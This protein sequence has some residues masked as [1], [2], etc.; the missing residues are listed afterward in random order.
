MRWSC[1]GKAAEHWH[2]LNRCLEEAA[3]RFRKVRG[4]PA[5]LVIDG[6]EFLKPNEPFMISLV[7]YAKVHP[8]RGDRVLLQRRTLRPARAQT[9]ADND[10]IRVVFISSAGRF[11]EVAEGAP[12]DNSPYRVHLINFQCSEWKLPLRAQKL[13]KKVAGDSFT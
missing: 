6:I 11:L 5:V 3:T 13:T 8:N 2:A 4:R 12:Q 9:W 10:D 1:A 7:G